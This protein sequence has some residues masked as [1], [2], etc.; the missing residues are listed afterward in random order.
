MTKYW[1]GMNTD[2]NIRNPHLRS[3]EELI[4]LSGNNFGNL[5]FLKGLSSIIKNINKFKILNWR[6]VDKKVYDDAEVVLVSC[7]NWLSTK[8]QDETR[9]QMIANI[10][11]KFKCPVVCFGLGM[12]ALLENDNKI[13]PN[14]I[15]L[16]EAFAK[17]SESPLSVRDAAT[18]SILKKNNI[19]AVITGCPSNFISKNL[20]ADSFYN[21]TARK[22]YWSEV[23]C[24]VSEIATQRYTYTHKMVDN[25]LCLLDAS[26]SSYILQS[27]LL[28]PLITGYKPFDSK[29]SFYFDPRVSLNYDKICTILRTRSSFFTSA[30]EWLNS[31]RFFDFSLGMRIHGTMIPLQ[32]STPAI[33][34]YHDIRT[35]GLSEAMSVPSINVE[36]FFRISHSSPSE[37]IDLFMSLLPKYLDKRAE[38]RGTWHDYLTKAGLSSSL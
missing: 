19:N 3:V 13:G 25:I 31:A 9:N 1:I 28:M 2:G 14:S 23:R 33:L 27:P 21:F 10:I 37:L 24:M 18:A 7:A 12:Q 34:V 6:Q 29:K 4:R 15:K 8:P 38:L 17:K 36:T 20:S 22:A 32:A 35:K 5:A 30:D 11:D 26:Q 16:A